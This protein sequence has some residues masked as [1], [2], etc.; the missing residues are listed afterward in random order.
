MSAR[1]GFSVSSRV[2]L[3]YYSTGGLVT[4]LL[5]GGGAAGWRQAWKRG[6][7]KETQKERGEEGHG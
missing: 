5:A 3:V 4:E 1:S 7:E 2:R 6:I